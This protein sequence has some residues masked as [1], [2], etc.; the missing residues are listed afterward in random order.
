MSTS[1]DSISGLRRFD[2]SSNAA[3]G[4]NTRLGHQQWSRPSSNFIMGKHQLEDIGEGRVVLW[5]EVALNILM[6][7][8][9]LFRW[10]DDSL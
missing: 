10:H 7:A 2:K 6:V 1:K 3:E 4:T 9:D 5:I 8:D